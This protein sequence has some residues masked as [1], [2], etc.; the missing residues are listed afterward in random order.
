[1]NFRKTAAF[2]LCLILALMLPITACNE[3]SYDPASEQDNRRDRGT[4]I[5][6]TGEVTLVFPWKENDAAGANNTAT[7]VTEPPAQPPSNADKGNLGEVKLQDGDLYAQIWVRNHGT[8]RIKL[9][10]EIA[11]LAVENFVQLAKDRYYDGKI[12]H[13]IVE[14]FM[15]QGGSLDG[16]GMSDPNFNGFPTEP[17][18]YAVHIYGAISTAN[19]S[20]VTNSNG[21]QFFIVNTAETPWLNGYHTVF[22]QMVSGHSTLDKLSQLPTNAQDRPLE[23]VEIGSIRVYVYHECEDCE[24]CEGDEE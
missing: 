23:A 14:D 21:Q 4:A 3:G 1:M 18:P 20:G 13:R 5:D 24:D 19:I 15:I 10:P 16:D 22:G 12:F 2:V 17:S 11:P 9:F 6:E 8:I 7:T